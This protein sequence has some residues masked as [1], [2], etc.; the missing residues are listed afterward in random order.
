[1]A[2]AIGCAFIFTSLVALTTTSNHLNQTAEKNTA[3]GRAINRHANP[4]LPTAPGAQPACL[5]FLFINS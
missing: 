3:F 1:M 4:K 5:R 2:K